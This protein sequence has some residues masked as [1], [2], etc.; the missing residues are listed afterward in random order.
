MQLYLHG[1]A[2]VWWSGWSSFSPCGWVA[3][4][5]LNHALPFQPF[6]FPLIHLPSL[7]MVDLLVEA[8]GALR[9]TAASSLYFTFLLPF[10]HLLT[11]S[12]PRSIYFRW[13]LY[14]ISL[15]TY[16]KLTSL[17]LTAVRH[18]QL[19]QGDSW[20]VHS[21]N[22]FPPFLTDEHRERILRLFGFRLRVFAKRKP[23]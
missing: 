15:I 2:C 8:R 22:S 3:P 9:A 12:H 10:P 13:C 23:N 6:P 16:L 21:C 5:H 11:P 18:V 4:C 1:R 7:S 14:S 19:Q 20:L 17:R